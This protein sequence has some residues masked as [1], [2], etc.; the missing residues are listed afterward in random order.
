MSE[1]GM[2]SQR[3]YMVP[4]GMIQ[5][6][7][8][9]G[10]WGLLYVRKRHVRR[11]LYAAGFTARAYTDEIGLLVSMLRRAE[12]RA[13]AS[14]AQAERPMDFLNQWLKWGQAGGKCAG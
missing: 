1:L 11:I 8:I 5:P 7:E 12:L 4:D 6:D 9:P 3:Y 10:R 14:H 2:G 13:I